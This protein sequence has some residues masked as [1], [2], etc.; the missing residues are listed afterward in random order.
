MN[1]PNNRKITLIITMPLVNLHR[2]SYFPTGHALSNSFRTQRWEYWCTKVLLQGC[3]SRG[4]GAWP[5][6]ILADQGMGADYTH[7]ITT[8]SPLPGFSDFP[9]SLF[10]FDMVQVVGPSLRKNSRTANSIFS[11]SWRK[12]MMKHNALDTVQDFLIKLGIKQRLHILK[13]II[14]SLNH[15][16]VRPTKIMNKVC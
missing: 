15:V 1:K 16:I 9:T 14:F 4:E 11:W 2:F 12:V 8:C 13:K 3:R 10:S 7:Q 6:Q 5:P